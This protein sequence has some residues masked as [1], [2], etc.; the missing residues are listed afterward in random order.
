MCNFYNVMR[1]SNLILLLFLFF[2]LD[3]MAQTMA[4]KS[5]QLLS[6]DMT[7]SC[8]G[9]KRIDQN[10]EVAALI[11][12]VTTETG[13]AFEGGLGIVDVKQEIGEVWVWVPH[14]AR[15][16]TIKHQRLGVLRDYRYP[17][18]IEAKRTYEMVLLTGKEKPLAKE[19]VKQQYLIFQISPSDASLEVNNMIWPVSADGSAKKYV[20]FGTYTYHIQAQGYYPETG[21]VTVDNPDNTIS[22]KVTLRPKVGWIEVAGDG[23]LKDANVYIDNTLVG[24][25]PC[26][27]EA[28]KT[29]RHNVRIMKNK[30]ETYDQSVMVN[31]GETTRLAPTLA[32]QPQNSNVETQSTRVQT[33]SIGNN[34]SDVDTNIPKTNSKSDDVF[35]LIIANENYLFLDK[36]KYATNDGAMFKE[37]CIKTLGIPERQIRYYPD[38]TFGIIAGGVDWLR[39]ALENFEDS[40][41]IV[42]YCG[43]GIPNEKTSAAYIIP[44]DGKGTNMA[45]CVSLNELYKTLAA[46]NATRITYFMDACFTGANKEGNMLVAA[47]GVAIKPKS[48]KLDGNTIVF[49]A[50][51][52]DETA[53]TYEEK[54]HG[55]FTYYLLKKLQETSGDVSYEELANYI[56]KK[57]KKDAFL[58]NE[59]PQ[60]PVVAT[61]PAVSSSWKNMKLK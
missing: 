16:I 40:R 24:K 37:Y 31:D 7:A 34:L 2:G 52:G 60:T 61:S 48:G 36:V 39:Y 41:G 25:A 32:L 50:S 57:V 22:V 6:K 56:S 15:K 54:Q 4:V 42:Y 14:G 26:K 59:K 38:A 27:S 43:H 55:L 44:I 5:F 49:S 12:I 51:S 28:L 30:Y 3:T 29:G 23:S 17:I 19:E 58:L 10:G 11:K 13:F 9:G 20:E 1:K 8:I 46:T 18:E 45:T 53:M 21:H 35:V 33:Q 47:R